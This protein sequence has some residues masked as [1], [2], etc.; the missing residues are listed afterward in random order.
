MD[1][2]YE[3]LAGAPPALGRPL[4]LRQGRAYAAA[5]PFVRRS[6]TLPASEAAGTAARVQTRQA[7]W[8]VRD[9]GQAFGDGADQPLAALGL[10]LRLG[11]RP[12][13]DRLGS[14]AG[15]QAYR[16]GARANPLDVV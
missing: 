10:E 5:W 1:A 6:Q 8:V 11:D 7:L 14:S 13:N 15:L 2:T 4:A 12:P 3:L 16:R 9:D